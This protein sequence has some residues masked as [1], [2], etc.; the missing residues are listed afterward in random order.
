MLAAALDGDAGRPADAGRGIADGYAADVAVLGG[1]DG[2]DDVHELRRAREGE[3]LEMRMQGLAGAS[4][5]AAGGFT[6]TTGTRPGS[7]F[8]ASR[9]SGVWMF[10][11]LMPF[12]RRSG[13]QP[14]QS[15]CSF[16]LPSAVIVF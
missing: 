9:N 10:G 14:G 15:C 7:S 3:R 12:S 16:L 11:W 1:R 5:G 4:P 2:R 8:E 13:W 6:C